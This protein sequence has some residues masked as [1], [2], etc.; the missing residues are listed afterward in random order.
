MILVR[1][2]QVKK[3]KDEVKHSKGNIIRKEDNKK[4]SVENNTTGIYNDENIV[5][6]II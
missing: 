4:M 2:L 1:M 3:I 6:L 5:K